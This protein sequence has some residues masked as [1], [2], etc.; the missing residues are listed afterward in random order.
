MKFIGVSIIVLISL[1]LA[2]CRAPLAA[3]TATP[4]AAPKIAVLVWERNAGIAAFCDKVVVYSTN[5]AEVSDCHGSKIEIRLNSS[6]SAQLTDWITTLRNIS[7]HNTD[8]APADAITII[9]AF[10]G[11]GTQ[12]ADTDSLNA[13]LAFAAELQAMSAG[14]P[15]GSP[16]QKAAGQALHDYLTALNTGD[17]ILAAKLYGGDTSILQT[18]NP[19]ILNDLPAL[20]ERACTQNGLNCLAPR[21]VH[22]RGPDASGASQFLVEFNNL[23]GT[24]FSVSENEGSL[25]RSFRFRVLANA[26]GFVV[27]DL[28]P[29]S[30]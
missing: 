7:Y 23:D 15:L 8:P 1:L 20:L 3:Q 25:T 11:E 6:Q 27:L 19:D 24:L 29:L 12:E 2:S 13:M 10:T 30:P 21:S 17:Y 18:W 5:V 22:Y 28:P 4:T 14:G 26:G 9:L 16:A